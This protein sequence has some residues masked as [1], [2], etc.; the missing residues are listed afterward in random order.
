MQP[1]NFT[2]VTVNVEL[3]MLKQCCRDKQRPE[4]TVE[5]RELGLCDGSGN[6]RVSTTYS[7]RPIVWRKCNVGGLS[8]QEGGGVLVAP[9][10]ETWRRC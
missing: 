5:R 8:I 1:R 4:V 9:G 6:T 7:P 3:R 10:T 2:A